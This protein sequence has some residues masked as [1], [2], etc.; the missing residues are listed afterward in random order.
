MEDGAGTPAATFLRNRV[1]GGFSAT[2]E[3]T[4]ILSVYFVQGSLSISRLAVSFFLKD[5][6]GLS[7]AQVAGLTGLAMLPWLVKPLY[8]FASDS[9][10]LF[11]YRR[12]GYLV[13]AG[14]V[15]VCGWLALGT[16]VHSAGGAVIA[17][18]ATAL[19]VAVS[20]VAADSLVVERVRNLPASKSGYLQSLCWGSSALGGLL[21]AA[22]SGGLLHMLGA[23][24]IFSITAAL[25]FATG[26]L[27]GLIPEARVKVAGVGEFVSVARERSRALWSAICNRSVL[28]PVAFVFCWQ[29]TPTPDAA[30]FFFSTNVLHFG[31]EFLGRVQLVSSAAALLGLGLY[32]RYLRHLDVKTLM[33]GATL[34]SVPLSLTQV[35]LVTR[36]NLSL[37]IS[38]QLF[39]LTDSA[40]LTALGQVAFMPTLVLAARLCPPG[41]EGTLFAALM[42]VYNASGATSSELGALLTKM[43]GVTDTDFSNLWLLVTI[44]S[45]SSLLALPLL[46]LIDEAPTALQEDADDVDNM[47]I[48]TQDENGAVSDLEL[49]S[50]SLPATFE[51]QMES[52]RKSEKST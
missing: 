15:G 30:L 24:A 32:Q 2:P 34:V 29:A 8:G 23:R 47:S 37:G 11:G 52:N 39:A 14:G 27:A 28:L 36:T 35:L 51:M 19:S 16:I 38:D 5:E 12:R 40:V 33:L 31:P 21:S 20:D 41:V 6:L 13:A 42:S 4:A 18:V 10:P 48:T 46:S 44:C 7:P 3:L 17:M 22:F 25:P 26:C 43:L 49:Q 1:L 9:L 45:F 50:P